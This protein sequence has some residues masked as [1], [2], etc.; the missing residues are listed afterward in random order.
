MSILLFAFGLLLI[1][2]GSE[3]LGQ[4]CDLSSITHGSGQVEKN[5][6][7]CQYAYC[8]SSVI[9][10]PKPKSDNPIEKR[11]TSSV[12]YCSKECNS[13]DDCDYSCD[14]KTLSCRGG[15]VCKVVIKEE[16]AKFEGF[17]PTFVG[18]KFCVAKDAIPY[19]EESAEGEGEGEGEGK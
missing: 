3:D 12:G 7:Q 14:D 5:F 9:Q 10:E 8:I 13:D 4:P 6:K 15:F 2:C 1:S 18:K 19:E 11:G 17:D 16:I